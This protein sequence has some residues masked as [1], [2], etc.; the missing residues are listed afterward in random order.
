[1]AGVYVHI[2]FCQSRCKYCDFYSTTFLAR[3][4]EYVIALLREWETR[5]EELS[6]P[7]ETIYFGGGT[8]SLLT[9]EQIGRLLTA[10]GTSTATEITLEAN[11]GDLTLPYLTALR[12]I[13]INRLSI[14]VQSFQD[15]LLQLIGRR[16]DSA[17]ARNAIRLAREAG[18][19][20]LSVDLMYGLPTQTLRQWQ[21]DIETLLSFCPEHISTYCLSYEEGTPLVLMRDH[22]EVIELGEDLLNTFYDY[23]CSQLKEGGYEH[24]EVSNFSLPTRHSHHNSNYWNNTPYIGLGAAAHS[25][26]GRTRSWNVADVDAYIQGAPRDEEHLTDEQLRLEAIMLGLRTAQ[27]IEAERVASKPHVVQDLYRRELID[28]KGSRI[29]V[30]QKGLHILNS[31]ITKLI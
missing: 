4:E 19:D 9:P 2:P 23:L 18:F 1:M 20:N 7:I 15:N 5:Q 27:G 25:Y 16:H 8:P 30:T 21:E 17:Q 29:V 13:G 28:L 6:E 26:D 12:A 24:Y 10:I 11:P 3:R 22:G 31:I 14:G